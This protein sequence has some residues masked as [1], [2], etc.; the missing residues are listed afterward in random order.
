MRNKDFIR[1]L[2]RCKPSE[3]YY[4]FHFVTKSGF[5]SIAQDYFELCIYCNKYVNF[6]SNYRNGFWTSGWICPNCNKEATTIR[7]WF[8]RVKNIK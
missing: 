4:I 2:Q 8:L 1:L 5:Y 6:S 3:P 7:E